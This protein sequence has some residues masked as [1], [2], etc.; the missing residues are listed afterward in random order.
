MTSLKKIK[1]ASSSLMIATCFA[2]FMSFSSKA[3]AQEKRNENKQVTYMTWNKN[4]PET[5]MQDDINALKKQGIDIKYENL[6]R[7]SK[8]EITCIKVDFKDDEGNSGNL[9]YN[10][11]N[12]IANIQFHKTPA[13]VGFGQEDNGFNSLSSNFGWINDDMN[14]GLG[15]NFNDMPMQRFEFG[16]DENFD[17]KGDKGNKGDKGPKSFGKSQSKIIIKEN[18]KKPLVIQDG[19]VIEGGEDYSKEEIEKIKK[20]NRIE[21]QNGAHGNLNFNFNPN[22]FFNGPG[23]EGFKQQFDRLQQEMD[24]MRPQ[25]EQP[26][27]EMERNGGVEKG[28]AEQTKK[29]LEKAKQE[30]LKARD[31]MQKA[32]EEMMKAKSEMKVRKA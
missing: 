25:L 2:V 22:E 32:R 23:M 27:T 3:I 16:Y 17:S 30:M 15:L 24:R 19:E 31:E 12:P 7:N 1:M 6:K 8:G 5:E 13:S 4:T 14:K 21:F 11:K 9:A 26:K 29:E 28:D 20:N 10:G 18:G